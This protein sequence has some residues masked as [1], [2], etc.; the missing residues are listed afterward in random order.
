MESSLTLLLLKKNI[1]REFIKKRMKEK[2]KLK[3]KGKKSGRIY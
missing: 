2:G 3:K 1:K